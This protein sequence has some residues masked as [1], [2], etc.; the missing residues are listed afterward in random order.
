[1]WTVNDEETI[2]TLINQQVHSIVTDIPEVA[3][4]IRES[5]TNAEPE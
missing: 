1:M 4:G 5:L 2:R 3:L